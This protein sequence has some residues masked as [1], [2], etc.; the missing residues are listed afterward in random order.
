MPI[1]L[2]LITFGL[3]IFITVCSLKVLGLVNRLANNLKFQVLGELVNHIDTKEKV[4]AL[5]YDD[6]PN[7]PYTNQLLQ[8][9]ERNQ[10][11]ATFFVI[12][13]IAEK[14]PEIVRL[15]LS[16]GHEVGNHSY[17][18]QP[19]I[20]KSPWYIRSEIE[21]TDKLLQQ[22]GVE[23]EIHFRAP[24]GRKLIALPYLLSRMCKKNILWDLD[25]KD[26]DALSYEAIENRVLEHVH[27]G[28]IILMHDGG[29]ERSQ[30]L[31]ATEVLIKKLKENGYKF[32]TISELIHKRL[33]SNPH[34][35]GEWH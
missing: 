15:I 9:L 2:T 12:G 3:I 21:K 22:L 17:S 13:K 25:S 27:P 11:R 29:G 6:G 8:L 7:P 18:H 31:I 32:K 1:V 5:T 4:V 14:H 24:Y 19:L 26:Y 16:N 28:S 33:D 30:T 23:Q 10:I 34:C 20:F 35:I